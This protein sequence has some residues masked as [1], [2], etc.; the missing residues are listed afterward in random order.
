[1]IAAGALSHRRAA[2]LTA[3]NDE[4]IIEHAAILQVLDQRSRRLVDVL[5]RGEHA[6]LDAAVMIPAA[7]IQLNETRAALSQA[8]RQ[9]AVARE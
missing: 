9:Q 7:M 5:C 2:E 8:P 6:V 4:R 1:M 3:P